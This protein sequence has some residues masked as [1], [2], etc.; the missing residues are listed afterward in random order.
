MIAIFR[1]T[2]ARVFP[3]LRYVGHWLDQRSPSPIVSRGAVPSVARR[4]TCVPHLS[5]PEVQDHQA[6][7]EMI[8]AGRTAGQERSSDEHGTLEFARRPGRKGRSDL[9]SASRS[10]CI[11]TVARCLSRRSSK[12]SLHLSKVARSRDSSR[13]LPLR[14]WPCERNCR[15]KSLRPSR[16]TRRARCAARVGEV[17][18]RWEVRN[19]V[20]ERVSACQVST[21]E[22]GHRPERP[23]SSVRKGAQAARRIRDLIVVSRNVTK[24]HGGTALDAVRAAG[25]PCQL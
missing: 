9:R 5:T 17:K 4:S 20:P 7:V 12:S 6:I 21:A 22:C 13:S 23:G 3:R 8:G 11:S 19:P 10:R 14:L 16:T 24:C 15:R 1:L 2:E 18:E 25:R